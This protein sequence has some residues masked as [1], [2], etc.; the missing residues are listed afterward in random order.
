MILPFSILSA[1]YPCFILSSCLCSSSLFFLLN[2]KQAVHCTFLLLRFSSFFNSSFV[3]LYTPNQ[4]AW[5]CMVKPLGQLVWVSS[6]YHYTYTP[7]LSTSSS[8]T[9]LTVLLTGITHLLAS[10]VLRCFQHLSLPHLAT[11]QCVWRHNRN[12][13]DASTPVLSY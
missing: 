1:F 6:M 11:R 13:S 2:S 3:S 9:T 5:G 8:Q 12:T 7:H 4:N 10:F